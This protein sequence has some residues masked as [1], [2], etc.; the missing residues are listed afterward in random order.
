MNKRIKTL[1]LS[2][3][4]AAL[5]GM[6]FWI[7]WGNTALEISTY[8][9]R[10]EHISEAFEGYRIV[11]ISDLHNAQMGKDNRKLLEMI[12]EAKPD[13]IAITGDL[14]DSRNTNIDVALQFAEKAMEIAPCY[15][16]TGNHESRI[17]EY[18]RLKKGLIQLGVVVLKNATAEIWRDQRKLVVMGID[19]PGFLP[20]EWREDSASITQKQLEDLMEDKD[21]FTVLL[22]HRPEMFEIYVKSN[23]DLALSGHVHGG[24]FRLPIVGGVVSPNREL[25]PK[26]DAGMFVKKETIMVVSRGIGN[27]I[28]PFRIN[29]R[30]EVVL[31]E[32]TGKG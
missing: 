9:V 11:H 22:S 2:L 29:N 32:L 6:I 8:I 19:D 10:S 27:S 15:Y 16:V 31:I 12:K 24:Q 14:I 28:I 21:S 17:P 30:P 7:V 23:V 4:L 13:M 1:V 25:F 20:E 18:D 26:Y 5:L 3:L